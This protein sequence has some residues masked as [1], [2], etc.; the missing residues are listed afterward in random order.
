MLPRRIKHCNVVMQ[1]AE[2]ALIM[3]FLRVAPNTFFIRAIICSFKATTSHCAQ[4]SVAKSKEP[5]SSALIIEA[6]IVS[7]LY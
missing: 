5:L 4:V 3:F 1:R 6:L 7:I 2:G